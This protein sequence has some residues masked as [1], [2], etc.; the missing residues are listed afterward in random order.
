M[1]TLPLC[2]VCRVQHRKL[3]DSS[4]EDKV[5]EADDDAYDNE[6]VRGMDAAAGEC[7]KWHGLCRVVQA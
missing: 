2:A 3:A 7:C 1:S 5:R 6:R 4:K